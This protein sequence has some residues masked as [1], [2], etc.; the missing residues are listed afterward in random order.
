MAELVD[1]LDLGSS[2]ARRGSSSLPFRTIHEIAISSPM[3]RR[4]V[5][6]IQW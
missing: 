3:L 6:L 4:P 5:L 2:A 1:A